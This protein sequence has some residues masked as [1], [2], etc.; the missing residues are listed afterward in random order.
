MAVSQTT[1]SGGHCR[2][3]NPWGLRQG[4]TR[5]GGGGGAW[6]ITVTGPGRSFFLFLFFKQSLFP[7]FCFFFT[8]ATCCYGNK[9][10]TGSP[11]PLTG[12]TEPVNKFCLTPG[13]ALSG[14]GGQLKQPLTD[15]PACSCRRCR[16]SS[17]KPPGAHGGSALPALPSPPQ[18]SLIPVC[19]SRAK[20][21]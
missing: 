1:A 3:G 21:T 12:L 7:S 13:S 8:R 16:P 2:G 19:P 11:E 15:S 18:H 9:D 20:M 5:P 4:V 6:E 17:G 14:P 10:G